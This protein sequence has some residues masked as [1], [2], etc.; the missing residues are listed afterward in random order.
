MSRV[1]WITGLSG[2][3]KTTL[4]NELY[5]VLY[6][7]NHSLILLDGDELRK[8]F[9][10]TEFNS[11][12]HG[13]EARLSLAM[14]YAR[15]CKLISVQGI[16]VIISTISLFKEVHLWNRENLPNYYEIYIKVSIEELRKRDP[17]GI[18]S[19][20][21]SG[22]ITDVAGLD[23]EIDEPSNP[24]FL[25]DFATHKANTLNFASCIAKELDKFDLNSY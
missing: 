25:I 4:A 7:N 9:Q 15:L 6:S 12:N 24:D 1:I 11:K 19:K 17:K 20:F 14:K 2:A 21:Y 22:S 8:V 5:N 18:Y 3:G 23:L 16:T 13:R 10:S